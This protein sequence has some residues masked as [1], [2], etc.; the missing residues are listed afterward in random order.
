MRFDALAWIAGSLL[1]G[2]WIGRWNGVRVYR[3][4]RAARTVQRFRQLGDNE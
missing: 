4:D 3:L 2:Y 1:I